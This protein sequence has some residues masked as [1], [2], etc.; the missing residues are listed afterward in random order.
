MSDN[1]DAEK[2]ESATPRKREKAREEG[3]VAKSREIPTV[4][5]LLSSLITLT[6]AGSWM[7]WNLTDFMHSIFL[8]VGTADIR[9]ETVNT[10]LHIVIKKVVLILLP[11]LSVLIIAG[12]AGNLF[13]VGFMWSG[14][15]LKPKLSKLNPISGIKKLFSLKS[16]VELFKSILKLIIVGGVAYLAI[17]SEID[18]FPGLVQFSVIELITFIGK[19]AFK[20]TLYTCLVL[21]ILAALDYF[22]Q[23][24]QYEKDLK[25]TKQEVKDEYKMREGDP[26]VKARIKSVQRE[27]AQKRMM[28]AVPEATV[29]ITNP[30]HLAIAIKFQIDMPAPLLVAKGAGFIAKQIKEI[31]QKHSIPVIEQK[32]LARIIYKTVEINE[33]IPEDLYKAVAEILAYVYRLKGLLKK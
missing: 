15:T 21:I 26:K 30:T 8:G 22:Y 27:M 5:I 25:M 24:W 13:Q 29:I 14:K 10:L 18:N 19:V 20:I 4:L 32:T 6:L 16:L 33:Y 23:R 17:K 7:F 28:E 9:V 12:I 31:A 3:N 1:N 2:T 11:L